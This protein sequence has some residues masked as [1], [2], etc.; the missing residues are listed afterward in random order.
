MLI[1][2]PGTQ[3]PG[4]AGNDQAR[5]TTPIEALRAGATHLVVGRGVTKAAD[6]LAAFMAICDHCNK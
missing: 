3:M 4:E 6:P 5:T 1:V 2:T